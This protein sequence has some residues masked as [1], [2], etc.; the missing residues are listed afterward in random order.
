[1]QRVTC[2]VCRAKLGPLLGRVTA[3]VIA[4]VEQLAGRLQSSERLLRR[5]VEEYKND[6][7]AGASQGLC[8][9]KVCACWV[10]GRADL[11]WGVQAAGSLCPELEQPAVQAGPQGTGCGYLMT[12]LTSLLCVSGQ[13]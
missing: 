7:S 2:C 5:E 6:P 10:P 8:L 13:S 11:R 3:G 12:P 4:D 9:I 1:M